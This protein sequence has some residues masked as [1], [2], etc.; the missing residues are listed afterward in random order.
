MEKKIG[1]PLGADIIQVIMDLDEQKLFTPATIAQQVTTDSYEYGK[2]RKRI[3]RWISYWAQNEADGTL[4]V[5]GREWPAYSGKTLKEKLDQ[6]DLI[7]YKKI[8]KPQVKKQRG[9]KKLKRMYLLALFLFGFVSVGVIFAFINNGHIAYQI[10]QTQGLSSAVEYI[11]DLDEKSDYHAYL[12]AFHLV[13]EK[14]FDE[15]LK[16]EKILRSNKPEKEMLGKIEYLRSYIELELGNFSIALKHINACQKIYEYLSMTERNGDVYYL[17]ALIEE[18]RNNF[19][20]SQKFLELGLQHYLNHRDKRNVAKTLKLK[21]SNHVRLL[22]FDKALEVAKLA[23]EN[24][25]P[26]QVEELGKMYATFGL[27]LRTKRIHGGMLGLYHE[28]L[29]NNQFI[30]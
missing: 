3:A 11:S 5:H 17:R 19:H 10:Y 23:L 15:S 28:E 24:T 13:R 27:Y 21:T 4:R 30:R 9:L 14:R 12:L 16:I 18:R 1:R 2:L 22:E 7:R 20:L 8:S 25:D 29:F 6:L 26:E